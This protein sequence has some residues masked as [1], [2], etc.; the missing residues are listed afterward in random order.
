MRPTPHCGARRCVIVADDCR[1][2]GN[3]VLVLMV[4]ADSDELRMVEFAVAPV[5]SY[6]GHNGGNLRGAVEA[7]W[8][9]AGRLGGD[10]RP[11]RHID[12]RASFVGRQRL[13]RTRLRGFRSWHGYD[14]NR[15]VVGKISWL[16]SVK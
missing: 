9:L 12:P 3:I 11:Y 15:G 14:A 8:G 4:C 6:F 1:D 10:S 13:R 5:A 7:D 16:S 2:W